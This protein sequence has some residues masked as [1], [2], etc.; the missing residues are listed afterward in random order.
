MQKPLIYIIS[1]ISSFASIIINLLWGFTI[2]PEVP[3][4]LIGIVLCVIG[5]IFL[6]IAHFY[7]RG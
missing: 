5:I 6:I 1:I 2:I 4:R 7:T 3:F